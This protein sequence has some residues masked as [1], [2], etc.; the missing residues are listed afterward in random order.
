MRSARAAR[1]AGKAGRK[2]R[3]KELWRIAIRHRS[4]MD[5]IV[6]LIDLLS[7]IED[8]SEL[9]ELYVRTQ[10]HEDI[11]GD[12]RR[13][14]LMD[15]Q[16]NVDLQ[17]GRDDEAISRLT[18]MVKLAPSNDLIWNRLTTLMHR[19]GRWNDLAKQMK[20]RI[21]ILE[22]PEELAAATLELGKLIEEKLGDETGAAETYDRALSFDPDHQQSLLARAALAYR[23]Q[24]WDVLKELL[25]RIAPESRT[26]ETERWQSALTEH[27]NQPVKKPDIYSTLMSESLAGE[28]ADDSPSGLS[29]ETDLEDKLANAFKKLRDDD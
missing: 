9:A 8:K 26:R 4:N 27:Q 16:V 5:W 13:L 18:A 19:R 14:K 17:A 2:D 7:A 21:H 12:P 29:E 22:K 6:Q 23:R 25:E 28:T 15:A 1:L 20:L 10:G 3:A 11:L 24:N